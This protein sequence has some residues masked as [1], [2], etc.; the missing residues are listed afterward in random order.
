M[1]YSPSRRDL[2]VPGDVVMAWRKYTASCI[3]PFNKE[4]NLT[5]YCTAGSWAWL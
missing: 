2:D 3:Q 4:N 1:L 5:L